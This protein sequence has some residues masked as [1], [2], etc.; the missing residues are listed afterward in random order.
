MHQAQKNRWTRTLDQ[1]VSTLSASAMFFFSIVG[2]LLVIISSFAAI[3]GLLMLAGAL[4][5]GWGARV[6]GLGWVLFAVAGFV[7]GAWTTNQYAV[8]RRS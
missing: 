2:Q 7:F 6:I 3:A 8:Q 1:R 4:G 5:S